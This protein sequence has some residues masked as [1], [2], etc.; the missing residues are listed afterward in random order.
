MA[1]K[2]KLFLIR[3]GFW[4]ESPQEYFARN[5]GAR[6]F[7]DYDGRTHANINLLVEKIKREYPFLFR[8]A[9]RR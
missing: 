7:V 5:P 6:L 9:R 2:I 8:P 3:C 4:V 1:L